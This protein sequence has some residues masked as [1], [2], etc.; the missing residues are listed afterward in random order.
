MFALI[1]DALGSYYLTKKYTRW[2]YLI[3]LAVLLGIMSSFI[4]NLTGF[5]LMPEMFSGLES[6]V[7]ALIGSIYN[8]LI[9]IFFMWWFRRQQVKKQSSSENP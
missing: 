1:I 7:K 3:P 8:P 9:C 6:T 5:L 4:A 2:L